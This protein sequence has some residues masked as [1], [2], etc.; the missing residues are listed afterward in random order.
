MRARDLCIDLRVPVF[1]QRDAECGNTSLK[2]V[3]AFLGKRLSARNLAVMASATTEGIDHQGLVV[4]AR[5]TGARVFERV[6][7]SVAELR[8]FLSQGLPAIAGWWS[9][10]EGDVD[11]DER[12]S[13]AE[14][15]AR[16]CGHFSVICGIERNRILLMDPS[17][18]IRCGRRRVPPC[19]RRSAWRPG[20]RD[21]GC[22]RW[23]AGPRGRA[24]RR[25]GAAHCPGCRSILPRCR[26]STAP[27]SRTS[28][29]AGGGA[30]APR[31]RPCPYGTYPAQAGGHPFAIFE[32]L[33]A[34]RLRCERASATGSGGLHGSQS[35]FAGHRAERDHEGTTV[36]QA[37]VREVQD[38]PPPWR[39]PRDL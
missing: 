23:P 12:W 22:G 36:G 1:G 30:G 5:R 38:H 4:A 26:R 27:S 3:L 9:P 8:W 18:H 17:W 19:H 37:D 35:R 33:R 25:R 16:D 31:D 13:P 39:R 15:R 24:H 6:E 29:P 7:G 34:K 21:S 11:H 20:S 14:R 32:Y 28:D 2:S 10:G